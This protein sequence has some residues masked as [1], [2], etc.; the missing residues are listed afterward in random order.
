[1]MN[2]AFHARLG[3][4]DRK[5]LIAGIHAQAHALQLDDETRR[6]MQQ[7]LVGIESTKD[8]TLAQLST[9]WSR[10]TALARDA[11]LAKPWT[12]KGRPGRDERQP[13]ELPT[14]EQ[15]AKIEALYVD[16][17][18]KH[19]PKVV[20][21]LCRRTTGHSWPQTR[22]EANRLIEALKAMVARHWRPRDMEPS[23]VGTVETGAGS[24]AEGSVLA[25]CAVADS[26]RSTRAVEPAIAAP[27]ENGREG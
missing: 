6:A 22:A 15:S 20:I 1:M 8:M 19:R 14:P 18:I 21:D 26:P 13:D 17:E 23:E 5:K 12:R 24:G 16:L 27:A 9:V 7:K 25:D 2:A 4:T 11:G 10:L 3:P